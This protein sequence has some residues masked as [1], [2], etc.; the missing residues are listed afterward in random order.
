MRS[1]FMIGI[2]WLISHEVCIHIQLIKSRSKVQEYVMWC[3]HALNFDQWETFSKKY[4][5]MR[6]WLGYK[7]L[8]LAT[9]LQVHSNSKEVSLS[10]WQ[11]TYSNLRTTCHIKLKFFLWTKLLENLLLAK[12][13]ISVTA[14]LSILQTLK[15]FLKMHLSYIFHS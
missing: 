13:L 6:D 4:K 15:C 2:S 12:Y 14:P 5:P 9:F 8:L 7:L 3:E 11:N 10:T 1:K